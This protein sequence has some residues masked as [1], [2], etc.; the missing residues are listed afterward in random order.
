MKKLIN[1]I[2]AIVCITG[3]WAAVSE[4]GLIKGIIIFGGLIISGVLTI[5]RK[6]IDSSVE[7]TSGTNNEDISIE[8]KINKALSEARQEKF[9]AESEIRRLTAWSN[10][11]IMSAYTQAFEAESILMQKDTLI[12][13]YESIKSEYG[14]K[15]SFETLDKCD[16]IVNDY[17]K[18]IEGYKSRIELFDKKQTEYTELK[19]KMKTLRQNEKL[20]TQ[21][22]KHEKKIEFA[23]AAEDKSVAGGVLA[24]NNISMNDLANEVSQREEYYKQLEQLEYQYKN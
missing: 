7:S 6:L 3:I 14:P 20:R 24:E 9:K 8:M 22:D 12:D 16:N 4:F 13:K 11:A 15:I 1:I 21:L 2:L 17:A 5:S 23:E 19:E 10:D 18:K